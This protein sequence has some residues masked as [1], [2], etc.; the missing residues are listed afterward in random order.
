MD[1][2]DNAQFNKIIE[3]LSEEEGEIL[4]RAYTFSQKAHNWQKRKSGE[5]YFIH[6]LA[7]SIALWNRFFD[8]DLAVAW[9]LHDAVEDCEE[10]KISEIYEEFW[11]NVWYIVDSVTKTED[12]FYWEDIVYDNERD[13]MLAWGMNNIGCILVKLADRQHNL[14]T[15]KYMPAKKQLKKSFE[16][17][18]LYLPLMHILWFDEDWLSL[19]KCEWLFKKYVEE[20]ELKGV[21]DIKLRLLNVC[22]EDFNEELFEVVYNNTSNVVWEIS[23]RNLFNELVRKG[24]FDNDAIELQNVELDTV[25]MFSVKFIYKKGLVFENIEGKMNISKNNFIS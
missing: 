4:N 19:K 6:P 10:L 1:Y 14:A 11:H 25:W 2:L 23:D 22:F 5:D 7:V 21:K 18:W 3:S 16:S 12:T 15:L 17:Q 9:L 20:N 8:V 24:W 13:K